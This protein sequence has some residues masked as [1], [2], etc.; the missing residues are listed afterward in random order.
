VF[1]LRKPSADAL[2]RL[3]ADQAGRELTYSEH[4]ATATSGEGP[5]GYHHDQWQADLGEFTPERFDQLA[6]ALIDWRIQHDSGLAIFPAEAVRPGLTFALSFRVGIAYVIATGR[7]V[8]VTS[9]PGRSGFAY[10]T[11]PGHPEQGEE[12]FHVE[13]DG[14]RLV[15][16]VVAFSKPRDPLAKLGAPV[17]R[18]LQLRMNQRYL[19]AAR[20]IADLL[21][22]R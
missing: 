13:K 7:V 8:Y 18:A 3:V 9:E 5:P 4:G 2:A 1:S 11:L 19:R 12:A 20:Q 6:Q 21:A 15:F 14:S 16:R 10:G 17:S 22:G